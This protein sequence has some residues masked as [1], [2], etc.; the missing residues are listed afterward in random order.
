MDHESLHNNA[1]SPAKENPNNYN[2]YSS[3]YNPD[4]CKWL[5]RG[6]GTKQVK[7]PKNVKKN[8]WDTVTKTIQTGKLF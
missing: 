4:P 3:K 6:P 8:D 1:N 2:F 5:L 7:A